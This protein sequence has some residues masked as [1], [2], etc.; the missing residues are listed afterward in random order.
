[1]EV[2]G[3]ASLTRSGCLPL[4]VEENCFSGLDAVEDTPVAA[5][6]EIEAPESTFK[7]D[8][9]RTEADA[10]AL[11]DMAIFGACSLTVWL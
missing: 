3:S 6:V 7:A 5:L 2:A 4:L 8:L 1:L 11:I 10:E 9:P